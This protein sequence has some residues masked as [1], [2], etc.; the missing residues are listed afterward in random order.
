VA[1]LIT[2]YTPSY[3]GYAVIC[4]AQARLPAVQ[5][6]ASSRVIVLVSVVVL[7][8]VA[9]DVAFHQHTHANSAV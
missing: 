8:A 5:S 4:N 7:G 3:H 1:Q 6:Q 2:F 9:L